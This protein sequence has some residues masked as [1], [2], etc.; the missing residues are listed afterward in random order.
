M[1]F[2]PAQVVELGLHAPLG[3][4]PQL[5]VDVGVDVFDDLPRGGVVAER[6]QR[7]AHLVEPLLAVRQI[8]GRHRLEVVEVGTVPGSTV[9]CPRPCS[10]CN[11]S[12]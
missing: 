5:F 3:G 1:V 12:R 6:P 10:R 9:R 11:D 7:V 2:K 4:V 8:H